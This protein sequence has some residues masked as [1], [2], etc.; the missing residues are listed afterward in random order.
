MKKFNHRRLLSLVLAIVMVLGMLPTGL[1]VSSGDDGTP[2]MNEAYENRESLVPIGA[3]FNVDTLLDSR[4]RSRC[5]LQ[6]R[7]HP[8]GP[9]R[10]G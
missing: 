1:A 3:S 7:Q 5:G 9:A 8:P 4:V 6:P 10:R 2:V